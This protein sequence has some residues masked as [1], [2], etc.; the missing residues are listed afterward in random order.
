MLNGSHLPL[1]EPLRQPGLEVLHLMAQG[2]SNRAIGGRLYLALDPVKGHNRKI[3]G[4]LDIQS[5]TEALARA[6]EL[7]LL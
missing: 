3:F 5:R 2:R 1:A 7:H 4:K 6:H